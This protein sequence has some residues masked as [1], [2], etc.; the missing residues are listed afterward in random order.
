MEPEICFLQAN[1][2]KV[3][4][5][6]LVYD[7]FCGSGSNLISAAHFGGLVIGSDLDY[8]ILYSRG[9]SSRADGDKLR[10]SKVTLRSEMTNNYK[11]GDRLVGTFRTDFSN[12]A[13]RSKEGFL[14]AIISDPPYGV[15]EMCKKVGSKETKK[16]KPSWPETLHNQK[17][18]VE[19]RD[20]KP[21]YIDIRIHYPQK[22]EY[23]MENLFI[24]LINFAARTLKIGGRLTFWLPVA[25]DQVDSHKITHDDLEFFSKSIEPLSGRTGRQLWVFEKVRKFSGESAVFESTFY[26]ET[27]NFRELHYGPGKV[28]S[29]E[30]E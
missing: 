12:T 21:D 18:F 2:A 16:S 7:P 5:Y 10:S 26:K 25:L 24:D 6:D 1:L 22:I 20:N 13:F 23:N 17:D 9:K 3:N 30:E 14:D 11:T 15:R 28:E 27:N 29:K 4:Q 8:N 19:N